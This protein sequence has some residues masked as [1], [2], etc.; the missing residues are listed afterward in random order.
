MGACGALMPAAGAIRRRL[1]LVSI[2]GLDQHYLTECDRL[3]LRIPVLRQLMREGSW[4]AGVVGEAPTVT[5][6]MH[7]T[8]LTGVPPRVHGILGNRRP[9]REGGDY[10]WSK[11]LI[12]VRTLWDACQ[13]AGLTT[14]AVTWPVT[15]T[16][17]I[18]YNLPEYFKRR[19]GGAMDLSSIGSRAHPAGLVQHIS[20]DYPSFAQQWLDDRC[21]MLAA[22]WML[23][24]V[25]PDFLAV[26]L[27]DLDAESHECGPFSREANAVLEY[28][29]ELL[30][31]LL[32]AMPADA[33]LAVVSDHGFML[34]DRTVHLKSAMGRAG[35]LEI[36]YGLAVAWD[37][38]A[39]EWL[40][41]AKEEGKLGIGRA[42]P[43]DELREFAPE[44]ARSTAAY[45]PVEGTVFGQRSQ[46]EVL[47]S[48]QERGMHGLWPARPGYR[49]VFGLWGA[50]IRPAQLGEMRITAIAGRMGEILQVKL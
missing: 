3:G 46:G 30:G 47:E 38:G 36:V 12:R 44:L 21:R 11:D 24:R 50:G 5:W 31:Q 20:R 14:A 7:T 10:Y 33:V 34:V 8:M 19:R 49:S 48:P 32:S 17:D 27:V 39:S 29:D 2:D 37:Q 26:H 13:D 41:R 42:V 43:A 18:D 9:A 4:A 40:S 28:T 6:P 35:R 22:R 45:E 1:V 23:E 15:V 16:G 25:K